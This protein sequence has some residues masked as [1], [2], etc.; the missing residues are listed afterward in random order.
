MF[1]SYNNPCVHRRRRQYYSRAKRFS[2]TL[3]D[4]RST[5]IAD[6]FD[7]ILDLYSLLEFRW[8]MQRQKKRKYFFNCKVVLWTL[9]YVLDINIDVPRL[10]NHERGRVQLQTIVE[11]L[12]EYI[13]APSASPE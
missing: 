9:L 10:K 3:R 12:P 6:S 5:V 11:L 13:E 4:M 1:A 7:R 2:K 8:L